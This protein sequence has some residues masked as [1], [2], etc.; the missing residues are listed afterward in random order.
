M[1][2]YEGIFLCMMLKSLY[3]VKLCLYWSKF[4]FMILNTVIRYQLVL[5]WKQKLSLYA[6]KFIIWRRNMFKLIQVFILGPKTPLHDSNSLLCEADY[7]C[8]GKHSFLWVSVFFSYFLS[9][10]DHLTPLYDTKCSSY[11]VNF[12]KASIH[13]M[14]WT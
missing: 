5:I 7:L 9:F 11:E 12:F 3:K 8:K 6:P 10:Y 14:E 13:Y 2:Y 1:P 4:H